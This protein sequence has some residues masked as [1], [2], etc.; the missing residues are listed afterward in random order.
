MG[1]RVPLLFLVFVGFAL[2]VYR[3]GYQELRGDEVFGYFLS[4][5]SFSNIVVATLR[6]R[7]PHPV[8]SYFLEHV[9]ILFAGNSEFSL[10]FLSA[11]FNALTVPLLYRLGREIGFSRKV[12]LLAALFLALNPYAIWNAQ[13]ARMYSMSLCVTLAG[14]LMFVKAFREKAVKYWLSYVLFMSLALYTHYFTLFVLLAQGAFVLYFL[15]EVDKENIKGSALSWG[16]IVLLFIPWIALAKDILW[17]YKGAESKVN[18]LAETWSRSFSVFVVGTSVERSV[19]DYIAFIA[20]VLLSVAIFYCW[21]NREK[22][23]FKMLLVFWV[24]VPLTMSWGLAIKRPIFSERYLIT[25]LPPF[26]LLLAYSVE[27]L[28]ESLGRNKVRYTVS[29]ILGSFV[30][31]IFLSLFLV[32]LQNYYFN[33]VYSKTRGWRNLASAFNYISAGIPAWKVRL[34]ENYPDPTLWYYYRGEVEHVVLPPS[35]RNVEG[36]VSIVKDFTRQ[37]VVRVILPVQLSPHWDP[38]GIAS[39]SIGQFFPL[40]WRSKVGVWPLE[41]FDRPDAWEKLGVAFSNGMVLEEASIH[42]EILIPGGVIAVH[43]K[44]NLGQAVL[45][46][47]LKTFIHIESPSGGILAQTDRPLDSGKPQASYGVAL[48][49]RIRSGKYALMV[50]LYHGDTGKR[51]RV[52]SGGDYVTLKRFTFR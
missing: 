11:W 46:D 22:Y 47:D 40:V 51:V 1:M 31:A 30:L 50:G 6:L 23:R 20:F 36:A 17:G 4:R 18:N 34:V 28:R 43:L 16:A 26:L 49:E 3:L 41:V 48:P 42:P 32:S 24:I 37:G 14:T 21:R 39:R 12:S 27:R 52:T 7:E 25:A 13:D 44:W 2:R 35:P 15:D 5:S 38:A 9:W 29:R 8:A 19:R 10:R 33:P 45:S